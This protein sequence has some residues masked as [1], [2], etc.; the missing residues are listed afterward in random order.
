[1]I[2][3]GELRILVC[4]ADV[5]KKAKSSRQPGR[6]DSV[7]KKQKIVR[8]ISLYSFVSKR[9]LYGTVLDDRINGRL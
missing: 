7:S 5:M 3:R 8:H 2:H 9:V 6:K 4:I 1:M